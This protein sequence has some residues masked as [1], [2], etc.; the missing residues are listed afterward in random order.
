MKY[1]KVMWP[2]EETGRGQSKMCREGSKYVWTSLQSV[3]TPSWDLGSLPGRTLHCKEMLLTSL[4]VVLLLYWL[5]G[6]HGTL[7]REGKTVQISPINKWRHKTLSSLLFFSTRAVWP[8]LQRCVTWINRTRRVTRPSCW[9]RSQPWSVQRTWR[10][11]RSSSQ[12]ETSM[13]RPARSVCSQVEGVD[14]TS[15]CFSKLCPNAAAYCC[16]FLNPIVFFSS[17]NVREC[18]VFLCTN[19]I[20]LENG[21]VTHG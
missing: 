16:W 8:P 3:Y 20:K 6:E 13:R 4:S 1:C 5:T 12:K 9:L 11:W 18:F 10:S 2:R 17:L 15:C 21:K 19:E 14:A 7:R